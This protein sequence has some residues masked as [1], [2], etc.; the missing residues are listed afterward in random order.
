M[1]LVKILVD[2]PNIEGWKKGDIVDITSP[3][4]LIEEKK[5]ELYTGAVD[6]EGKP[7]KEVSS[8]KKVKKTETSK[9]IVCPVCG[10]VCKSEFGLL[11]HSRVHK[12]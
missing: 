5:V 6:E 3:Q 10:K 7:V 12:V 9:K 8:V 4:R 11:S 1:P 2:Y